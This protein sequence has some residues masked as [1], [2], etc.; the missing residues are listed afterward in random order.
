MRTSARA[1]RFCGETIESELALPEL[2][3]TRRRNPAWSI[4]LDGGQRSRTPQSWFRHWRLPGGRLWLSIGRFDEGYLLRFRDQAEFTIG[5]RR[6]RI[7][8]CAGADLPGETLQHLLIDQVLPLA[9]S[10]Q[11]RLLLHASAVHLPGVGAVAFAGRTGRGKSTLAAAL[12][13]R[14]GRII[15]DDCLAIDFD[16]A[17]APPTVVPAYP[18]LRLWPGA[19]SHLFHGSRGRRVAHYS[20]KRRVTRGVL[21]FRAGPSPL[22]A[23]FVLSPRASS[24]AALSIRPIRAPR[25]L[26]D[27]MRLT[28]VLDTGNRQQ[29][30]AL[31]TGL[32]TL[33]ASVPVLRLRVR[34]GQ[35]RLP[36]TADLIR[37]Y[38]AGMLRS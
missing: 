26:A 21:P 3:R 33:A 38:A 7:T 6:N 30:A 31:F 10:Y 23:L 18:G 12:G 29:L 25:R 34:H 32:A 17:A 15:T 20:G 19:S 35:A 1:Y 27:L 16:R 11:G 22:R 14:G 28:Y 13:A 8:V 24:G 4:A 36:D 2:Q 9:L 5:T 37:A